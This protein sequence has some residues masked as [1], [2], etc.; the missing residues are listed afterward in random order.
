MN[1]LVL[2]VGGDYLLHCVNLLLV[3]LVA[4]I[5]LFVL[6]VVGDLLLYGVQLLLDNVLLL[7]FV[8][9]DLLFLEVVDTLL[10]LLF[11]FYLTFNFF[12]SCLLTS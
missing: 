6:V 2:V 12:V 4:L 11:I 8:L 1:L 3:L 7:L 5:D 9:L 10:R